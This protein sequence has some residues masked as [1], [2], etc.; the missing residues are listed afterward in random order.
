MELDVTVTSS[1]ACSIGNN[2]L[3]C[4][5]VGAYI[6]QHEDTDAVEV[7]IRAT[8]HARYE[9]VANLLASLQS[10]HVRVQKLGFVNTR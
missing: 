10:R 4:G 8:P 3:N 6:L 1:G 7:R 9:D 5:E 2:R